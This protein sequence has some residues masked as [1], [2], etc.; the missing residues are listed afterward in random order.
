[1]TQKEALAENVPL[2]ENLSARDPYC[3]LPKTAFIASC[4]KSSANEEVDS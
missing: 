3:F 2:H 1:M 4:A